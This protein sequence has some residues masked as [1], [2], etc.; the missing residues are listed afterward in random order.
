MSAMVPFLV[1]FAKDTSTHDARPG[2][3]TGHGTIITQVDRETTD[4]R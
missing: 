4:D 1:K 2:E 3:A